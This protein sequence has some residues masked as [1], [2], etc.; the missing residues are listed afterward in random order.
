MNPDQFPLSMFEV[1]CD[2][3]A[4][5]SGRHVGGHVHPPQYGEALARVIVRNHERVRYE[6]AQGTAGLISLVSSVQ[7]TKEN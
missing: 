6:D 3:T 5:G 1:D 7:S 4:C 2:G